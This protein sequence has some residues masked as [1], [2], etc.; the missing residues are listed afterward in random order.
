[1]GDCKSCKWRDQCK[2]PDKVP[3]C[4]RGDETSPVPPS[5][6]VPPNPWL[7]PTPWPRP[8]I[9]YEIHWGD[10]TYQAP[11]YMGDGIW[12]VGGMHVRW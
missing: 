2:S 10:R 4:F 3:D 5:P 11:I 1:M 6:W 9:P 7:E 8:S 12:S